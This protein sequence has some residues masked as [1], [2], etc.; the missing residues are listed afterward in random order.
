[1]DTLGKRDELTRIAGTGPGHSGVNVVTVE[2]YE[3]RY[4]TPVDTKH[5]VVMVIFSGRY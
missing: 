1:M 3:T 4:E 2:Q 5:V